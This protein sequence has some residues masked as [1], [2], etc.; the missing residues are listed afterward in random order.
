MTQDKLYHLVMTWDLN[1]VY[2]YTNGVLSASS[3]YTNPGSDITGGNIG[4]GSGNYVMADL[5]VFKVYNKTL[6]ATEIKQ[7]YNAY[8]KRFDL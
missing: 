6:S 4:Q 2:A 5:P 3:S 1:T 8:K 7:N